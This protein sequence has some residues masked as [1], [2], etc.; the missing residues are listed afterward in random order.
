M[1]FVKKI[2]LSNEDK[3]LRKEFYGQGYY[4]SRLGTLGMSFAKMRIIKLERLLM[5]L[6]CFKKL[7]L[8]LPQSD[9]W[10]VKLNYLV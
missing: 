5:Y 8:I 6:L 1:V 7:K 2:V 9:P 4:G 10:H 3:R